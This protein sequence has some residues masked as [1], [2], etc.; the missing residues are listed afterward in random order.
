MPTPIGHTF[1][2]LALWAAVR[3]PGSPRPALERGNMAWAALAVAASNAPDLDF[4]HL[5]AGGTLTVSGLYHHGYTHSLG[6]ALIASLVV[7]LWARARAGAGQGAALANRAA[8]LV[9]LCAAAHVALDLLGVD[10]YPLNGI[11]LP[12][13]W[14]LTEE[15]YALQMLNGV[16][17]HNLW[18]LENLWLGLREILM[19]GALFAAALWYSLRASAR[20][21]G[22]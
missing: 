1:T 12:V 8:F 5:S 15:Y 6:F 10:T 14:P 7:W 13:F 9:F 4:I 2:G 19:Y 17:R 11:G 18:S 22:T 21:R 20:R 3:P 16:D